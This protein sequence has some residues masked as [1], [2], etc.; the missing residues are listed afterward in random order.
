MQKVLSELKVNDMEAD[1]GQQVRQV[2]NILRQKIQDEETKVKKINYALIKCFLQL[3]VYYL[4][5]K[6]IWAQN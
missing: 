3:K 1:V 4:A 5:Q 6:I 2:E